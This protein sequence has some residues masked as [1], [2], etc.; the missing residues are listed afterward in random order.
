MMRSVRI[1][2]SLLVIFVACCDRLSAQAAVVVSNYKSYGLE[3]S[4]ENVIQNDA[5]LEDFFENLFQQQKLNDRKV[6]IIHIGDSHIQADY[7]TSVIRRSFQQHFGNA[8]RGLIVPYRVAGTNEPANFIT[9]SPSR[10]TAKRIVHPDNPLP[11]GI[12]GITIQN[13]SADVS[14]EV[15]LNDLWQ[16]Y[17]FDKLTL[18][19][20]KNATSFNYTV[21]DTLSREIG[22]IDPNGSDPFQN[23]STVYFQQ[24]VT[25]FILRTAKQNVLQNQA[26]IFGMCLENSNNGVLYHAIG[27]NGA[28]YLHYNSALYFAKQTSVL[29]PELFVISLGTN[30]SVEYPYLDQNF[31]Q[32]IDKL[33]TSL[34]QNNPQSNF[35]LVTPPDAFRR[36]IKK[37]PGIQQVREKIIAYAV[38]NG[39]A[40]YDMYKA[41]GGDN[42]A[43]AW[44]NAGL[45]RPDGVHFSKDGYEYQGNL[46]FDALM[47]SYNRYVPLRHP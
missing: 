21:T 39:Y 44:R 43:T 23:Y 7:L 26:T 1:V 13:V 42:S 20:L 17:A 5:H 33:I 27:V 36:K 29:K 41:L 15:H 32:H 46:L 10:W 28:K 16:D 4:E 9:R 35:I 24:P 47:K 40:F 11:I 38:E 2:C 6:S 34:K 31:S 37:N 18:F 8:G 19:Y 3:R 30:E 45:L 12:G 14:L 25:S 22:S